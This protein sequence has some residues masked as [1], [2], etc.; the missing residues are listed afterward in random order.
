MTEAEKHAGRSI[1]HDVSVPVSKIPTF[2]AEAAAALE[3]AYPGINIVT[4]GHVGDGN[5]HYNPVAPDGWTRQAFA[6]E[7]TKVNRII[8]DLVIRHDG[9]I[10][11]EHGVGRLRLDENMHY[12]S[13][14]EIE[15]M[16]SVKKALDLDNIMNP[17]KVIR[18]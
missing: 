15:L 8:H 6:G 17:G 18:L 1:K 14:V 10:S 3:A 9:S 5:M 11:A 16:R 12:K 2:L 4:F 13:A 7:R